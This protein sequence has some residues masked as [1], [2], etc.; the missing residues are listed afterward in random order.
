MMKV[1]AL[2]DDIRR[3]HTVADTAEAYR[4]DTR[5]NVQPG[6]PDREKQIYAHLEEIREAMIP[7]R[8]A[9]GRAQFGQLT[10]SQEA[11][12]RKVSAR[13][14]YERKQLKKMRR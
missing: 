9:L 11:A 3:G 7:I 14:Q 13:L 6:D 12:T 5:W 4:Q 1:M 10:E 8:A 2:R